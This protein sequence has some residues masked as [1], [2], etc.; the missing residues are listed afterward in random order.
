MLCKDYTM[1]NCSYVLFEQRGIFPTDSLKGAFK[2]V[3]YI[4]TMILLEL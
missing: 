2:S 1:L 3:K 4:I